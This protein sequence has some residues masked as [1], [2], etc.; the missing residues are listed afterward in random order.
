MDTN[1]NVYTI[2]YASIIV[3]IVAVLLALVSQ[4]LSPRQEANRLLD[5]Q[6]QIL[7]ALNQNYDNTDPAALYLS[8][9]NDTIDVNGAPVFVANIEGNTKYVLK[10][11]GAGLWGGIGGYLAL[12]ADK[13]TI[14]GVNF[15]HE[16]ETPGLGAEIVTEKFRT[17]FFGKHIRNAAGEVV[18]VAVLKAGKM[19]EGQ[20][21]V[22]ALSGA[23]I[24]CDGVSTMIA[25]NLAEYAEFLN[26]DSNVY[27]KTAFVLL[28]GEVYEG[29]LEAIDPATI[30]HITVLK[31]SI[32]VA[33]YGEAAKD[34][35][36]VITTK[37]SEE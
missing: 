36:I 1:S 37:K 17:Q 34:G 11:H 27:V 35:A 32:A 24:T 5:Q 21:Q 28:D 4:V 10:L 33:T 9:V 29:E 7:V 12:D 2:V 18:S 14:Y 26:E 16:S 6:K 20:E 13:N 23:T 15:N 22:D 19:A 25:T 30:E 3:V 31:D 8:L